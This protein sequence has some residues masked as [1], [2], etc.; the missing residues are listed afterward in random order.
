[1]IVVGAKRCASRANA[2]EIGHLN[3]KNIYFAHL[4]NSVSQYMVELLSNT[5][6]RSFIDFTLVHPVQPYTYHPTTYASTSASTA[7][8]SNGF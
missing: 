6:I 4:Q 2:L 7:F 5:L 3:L 1:M 8:S